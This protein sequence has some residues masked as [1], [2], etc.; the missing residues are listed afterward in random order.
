MFFDL[1][2]AL[3]PLGAALLLA[4]RLSA[5]TLEV[6]EIPGETLRGNPLGDPPARRA[7]LFAPDN[8]KKSDPAPLVVYLPGWGGSSEGAIGQ[9]RS[10]Y[11]HVV[12]QLAGEG[13]K[14]RIVVVDCRSRY[15]GSQYLNSPATG[16]YDDYILNEVIPF[17][18]KRF[19][20]A[21]KS[22][23]IRRV[24]M[25]HS[26][27]GYGALI[28]GS[29]HQDEFQGVAGLSPDSDFETSHRPF[30][31]A[32][33][34]R[35]V[36]QEELNRAM[37]PK[38]WK[39]P[40]DGLVTMVMGLSANYAPANDS[41]GRF[42]WIYDA[43]GKFRP[44]VWAKWM[45]ADP[46]SLVKR[47]PGAYRASQRI[48]LDGAAHDE[49]SANIGA[50]KIYDVLKTRESP[51]TF[52]EPPGNHSDNLGERMIRGLEWIFR[53][54]TIEIAPAGGPNKSL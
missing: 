36:T 50:R 11:E 22:A 23:E 46:L 45:A 27:G 28:L 51:V 13:V 14:L 47:D 16:N 25:G 7:A 49:F 42:E 8:L 5:A 2:H 34:V 10:M 37:A 18:E 33:A 32:P 39:L 54:P 52:C 4:G 29:R 31:E 17:V 35:T 30:V 1:R 6:L 26:S 3:L 9:S 40:N 19:E 20:P 41:P 44:D 21:G 24:I 15:T 38:N 53:L 48:Y 43:A 12:D